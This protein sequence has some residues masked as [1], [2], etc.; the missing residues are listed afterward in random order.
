MS[1]RSAR[2]WSNLSV[3]LAAALLLGVVIA[4]V[5]SRNDLI[6]YPAAFG[7]LGYIAIAGAVVSLIA[8]VSWI[9]AARQRSGGTFRAAMTTIGMAVMVALFY[10]YQAAP[11]PGPFM[12]DI[13]TDLD[14]PPEFIAVLPLRSPGSNS[15][16]YGGAE[17]AANQRRV[18]PE[19]Q[20]IFSTL[21]PGSAF[22]RA[23]EVAEDLGWE[24]VAND[25]TAGRIEAVDTTP[26]FRFKDDIV[27]R[28]RP[29]ERG[30]RIDLRSHSR[31]GLTDLGKNASRIMT[32]V[33]AYPVQG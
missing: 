14:D 2:T 24:I 1:P 29:D 21:S 7:M 3:L 22:D 25:R 26:F 32:F 17:V 31:I 15:A 11:P 9:M 19:V 5:G 30:S 20:P 27:I 33:R 8:L 6:S 13:T 10:V 28:I 12:N 16:D 23:V 4:I 18:H